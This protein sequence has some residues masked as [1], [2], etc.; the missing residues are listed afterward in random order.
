[1]FEVE[2]SAVS[3]L[4][5]VVRPTACLESEESQPSWQKWRLTD[6]CHVYEAAGLKSDQQSS[7]CRNG[8]RFQLDS[9]YSD[10]DEEGNEELDETA[11]DSSRPNTAGS[12][13]CRFPN[14]RKMLWMGDLDTPSSDESS[15][16]EDPEADN[17]L[18]AS[19]LSNAG[20]K[21]LGYLTFFVVFWANNPLFRFAGIKQDTS[22]VDHVDLPPWAR[23]CPTR[24]LLYHREALESEHV[25]RH[26]HEWIDLIF[27]Y[28]QRGGIVA[29][30]CTQILLCR[31]SCFYCRQ[32]SRRST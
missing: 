31:S 20:R 8:V 11:S 16:E 30:T 9:A 19:F 26:L 18:D 5:E 23:E 25:S 2:E 12:E 22:I 4:S 27:G 15:S 24:F 10:E 6:N 21:N 28:K 14:S 13:G 3:A 29:Y 1:M 7:Y 32:S 17:T